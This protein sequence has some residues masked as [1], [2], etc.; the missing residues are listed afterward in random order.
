MKNTV[1]NTGAAA[2][3][4]D[5]VNKYTNNVIIRMSEIYP[6]NVGGQE[7]CVVSK[8]AYAELLRFKAI[9]EGTDPTAVD[10]ENTL[11]VI[12]NVKDF[13]PEQCDKDDFRE[14]SRDDFTRLLS[15]YKAEKTQNDQKSNLAKSEKI[16]IKMADFYPDYI[17]DSYAEVSLAVYEQLCIERRRERMYAI[18]DYRHLEKYGFDEIMIG[19]M[20]AV[21]ESSAEDNFFRDKKYA[22]LYVA[23]NSID[24]VCA[25]RLYMNVGLS[26]KAVEIGEI[27]GVSH[28]AILKSVK[29]A[30]EEIRKM[31]NRRDFD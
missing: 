19:E 30:L 22:K 7:Y 14:I 6:E 26:M 12:I 8:K 29:K 23:L 16:I 1:K 20:Q 28:A 24:P 21:Y 17:G 11:T 9:E 3:A 27:E 25:R 13:Y 5:I 31:L 10:P 2:K 15:E 4:I 18:R